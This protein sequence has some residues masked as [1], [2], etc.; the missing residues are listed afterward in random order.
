MPTVIDSLV[1]ELG[2]DPSKLSAGQRQALDQFKTLREQAV[3]EGKEVEAQGRRITDFFQ[4]LQTE[5]IGIVGAFC[6]GRGIKDFV[7]WVT[8]VDAATGRLGRTLNMS[9]RDISAW[10]G[11]PEQT[12]G[13]AA[14][15]TGSLQGL[16]DQI[17]RF[18]ITGEGSVVG[19]VNALNM[20][21]QDSHGNFKTAGALFLE[22]NAALAGREPGEARSFLQLLGIDDNTVNLLLMSHDA[23]VKLLGA[24]EQFGNISQH[25]AD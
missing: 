20:G 19:V 5:A 10:Q 23:L 25:D 21:L 22:M 9:T 11:A 15:V 18:R 6:G 7:T 2:L 14:G 12:G 8:N 16:T 1:V 17:N 24:Q 13:T 4:R 3:K